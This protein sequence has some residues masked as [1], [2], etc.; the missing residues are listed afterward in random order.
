[1]DGAPRLEGMHAETASAAGWIEAA[2][3]GGPPCLFCG[4]R[5]RAFKPLDGGWLTSRR[6]LWWCPPCE[7]TWAA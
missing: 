5:P 7:T 3:D 1:M 4:D 2:A 6:R